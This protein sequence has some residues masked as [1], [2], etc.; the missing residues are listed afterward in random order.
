MPFAWGTEPVARGIK[1]SG[2][3]EFD[4]DIRDRPERGEFSCQLARF[5]RDQVI[6]RIW[7]NH[8]VAV[9]APDDDTSGRRRSRVEVA[10]LFSQISAPSFQTF[11]GCGLVAMAQL[12]EI[13]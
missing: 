5:L 9:F 2:P 1:R 11:C 4:V 7:L 3:A 13:V 12:D 8:F 10:L 6:A